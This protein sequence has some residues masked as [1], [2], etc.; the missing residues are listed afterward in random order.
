MSLKEDEKTPCPK[1]NGVGQVGEVT[2]CDTIY[3]I[4]CPRCLGKRQLDWIEKII[5]PIQSEWLKQKPG[6]DALSIVLTVK[7]FMPPDNYVYVFGG[8]TYFMGKDHFNME[9]STRDRWAA[10]IMNVPFLR[11][12]PGTLDMWR[13]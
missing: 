5:P 13:D 3:K 6:Y 8:T 2:Y 11:E 12:N 7:C 10:L 1:C 4:V 9:L